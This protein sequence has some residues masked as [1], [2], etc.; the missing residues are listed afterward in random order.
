MLNPRMGQGL[1][2]SLRNLRMD[3]MEEHLRALKSNGAAF[4]GSNDLAFK[5]ANANSLDGALKPSQS[6]P[7]L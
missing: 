7:R 6:I 1:H 2:A 4:K 5:G 3:R